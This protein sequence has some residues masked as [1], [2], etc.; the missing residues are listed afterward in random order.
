MPTPACDRRLSMPP[1][2]FG[3][4]NWA[5]R[6]TCAICRTNNPNAWPS[7]A[8]IGCKFRA[9]MTSFLRSFLLFLSFWSAGQAPVQAEQADRFKPLNLTADRQGTLDL[10]KKVVVFTGNV[11]ITKG[12][13]LMEADRVEIRDLPN[14]SRLATAYG[15]SDKQATFRQKRDKPNEF[16]HGRADRLEYDEKSDTVRFIN[17]AVAR[18]LLG[19]KVVD[20]ITGNQLLY[21]SGAE[22]FS[23]STGATPGPAGAAS[24]PGTRVRVTLAP[25]ETEPP[26]PP[27]S[28]PAPAQPASAATVESDMP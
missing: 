4:M 21:D 22:F 5:Q 8:R 10:A 1:V 23:A 25:R 12:T 2:R 15:T 17:R 28:A 16:I 11:V 19:D 3:E 6:I 14:G 26:A 27:A 7:T 13:L 18:R 20:E 24:A 9:F